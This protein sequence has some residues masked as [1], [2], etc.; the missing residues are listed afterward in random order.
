[1]VTSDTDTP[2]L[3]AIGVSKSYGANRVLVDVGFRLMAGESVAIIGEN[4][5]GKSTFA[6]IL[7]GVIRP[8]AGTIRVHG[9]RVSSTRRAMRCAT[10]SPSSR[11]NS[12]TCRISRS[13]RTSCW[14]VGRAGTG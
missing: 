11:R 14:G 6:K 7:A 4:G 1:M 2:L 12:P 5:A 3:E 9:E 8:D 13:P 10:A